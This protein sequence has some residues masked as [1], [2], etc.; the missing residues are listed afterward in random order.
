VGVTLAP[1][2]GI[3]PATDD[4]LEVFSF[5]TSDDQAQLI[6]MMNQTD[7]VIEVSVVARTM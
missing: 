7:K 5:S 3:S 4:A 1:N 6:S 2:G